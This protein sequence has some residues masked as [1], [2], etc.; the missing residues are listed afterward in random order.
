MTHVVCLT[1]PDRSLLCAR[2]EQHA[3]SHRR[4]LDALTEAGAADA[5]A[6]LVALRKMERRYDLDL[7]EISHRYAHRLDA[8]THPIERMVLEFIA[9]E[10]D[11]EAGT[12]LWIMPARVQQV[13]EL[14][15]G[16]LVGEPEA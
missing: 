9:E 11:G 12:Q 15:A 14:M 5:S 8:S 10:K 4:M 1:A 7:A 6:R 13:R 3:N 2:Y 16:R